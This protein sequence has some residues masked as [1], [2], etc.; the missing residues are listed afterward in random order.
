[1]ILSRVRDNKFDY[2]YISFNQILLD[3]FPS[4]IW[5]HRGGRDRDG[6]IVGFTTTC[7]ISAP[8]Y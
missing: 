3:F 4:N 6:M 1:M 5:G 8:H 7:A 2:L